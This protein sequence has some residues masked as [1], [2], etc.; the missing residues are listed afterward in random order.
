MAVHIAAS[1]THALILSFSP[2]S[3]SSSFAP[4]QIQHNSLENSL[5]FFSWRKIHKNPISAVVCASAGAAVAAG[6]VETLPPLEVS[7]IDGKCK[8]WE[9][10]GYAINYFVYPE[11]NGEAANANPPLLLVHGFGASIAHWRRCVSV[12]GGFLFLAQFLKFGLFDSRSFFFNYNLF[13]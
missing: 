5:K 11:I 13:S 10:R 4:H 3:S 2:S 7:E 9:W 8:K 1:A 6:E 12:C